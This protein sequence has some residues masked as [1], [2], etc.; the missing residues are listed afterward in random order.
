MGL[1]FRSLTGVL[2]LVATATGFTSAA[3]AEPTLNT[4]SSG[5]EP[6]AELFDRA[7]FKN[8]PNFF[9]NRS[10]GRQL[11]LILG[12][13]SY[14]EK[15]ILR[16]AESINNL[17]RS[18]IE[19]QVSRDPIIRTPDLPNPYETSVL[20][21]TSIDVNSPPVGREFVFETLPRP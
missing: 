8:D 9:R 14:P 7:F 3:T 15:E 10:F 2:I 16:D 13:G 18:A 19:R 12:I 20:Q 17:Y 1:M 21:S 4:Q 6:T 11:N 5:Y